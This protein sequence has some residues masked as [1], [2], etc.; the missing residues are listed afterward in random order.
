MIEKIIPDFLFTKNIQT[1]IA[2]NTA[3]CSDGK[4]KPV[5]LYKG[6][7]CSV[8]KGLLTCKIFFKIA[9][10]NQEKNTERKNKE[11]LNIFLLLTKIIQINNK[12]ISP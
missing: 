1:A 5:S 10:V 9:A 7:T 3:M 4:E 2:V 12:A 8:I 6:I 11:K